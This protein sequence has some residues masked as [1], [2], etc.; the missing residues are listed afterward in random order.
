MIVI[1]FRLLFFFL[2]FFFAVKITFLFSF[3][4]FED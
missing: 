2:F 4:A 3:E 1:C